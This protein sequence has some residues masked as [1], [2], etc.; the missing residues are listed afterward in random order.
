MRKPD[1]DLFLLLLFFRVLDA[2]GGDIECKFFRR[3]DFCLE[4]CGLSLSLMVLLLLA[5][6]L[7]LSFGAVLSSSGKLASSGEP[8]IIFRPC[9]APTEMNVRDKEEERSKCR[10]RLHFMAALPVSA[11]T[12]LFCS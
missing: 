6:L 8:A 3:S 12:L 1:A 7:L 11:R 2:G 4:L 10:L 5:L 9:Y